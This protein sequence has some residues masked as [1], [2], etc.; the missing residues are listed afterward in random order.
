M[1]QHHRRYITLILK[2]YLEQYDVGD[3]EEG[4]RG[5]ERREGGMERRGGWRGGGGGGGNIISFFIICGNLYH[6]GPKI[7]ELLEDTRL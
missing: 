6:L 2:V 7:S 4:G 1:L 3:G 5:M